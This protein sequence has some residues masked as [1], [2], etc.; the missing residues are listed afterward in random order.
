MCSVDAQEAEQ[1]HRHKRARTDS[2]EQVDRSAFFPQA[3]T[4]MHQKTV[5]SNDILVKFPVNT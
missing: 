3:S 1:K 4:A 5:N 2:E